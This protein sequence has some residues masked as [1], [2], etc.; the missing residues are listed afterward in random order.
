MD[1]YTLKSETDFSQKMK[2]VMQ[3]IMLYSQPMIVGDIILE[4]KMYQLRF[5]IR[6]A[7]IS[8]YHDEC[9]LFLQE[10]VGGDVELIKANRL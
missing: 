5:A 2:A 7:S 1:F 9:I 8:P 4:D 3:A 6:S 10:A